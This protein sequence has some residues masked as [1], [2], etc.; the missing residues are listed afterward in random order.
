[1]TP[2]QLPDAFVGALRDLVEADALAL[3]DG[4]PERVVVERSRGRE[5]GDYAS[6][7]ALQLAGSAGLPAR[8]LAGL[9]AARLQSAGGVETVEVAGPGFLNV[10]LVPDGHAEVAARVVSAGPSYGGTVGVTGLAQVPGVVPGVLVQRIGADAARYATARHGTEAA[11]DLDLWSRASSDN[12]VYDVQHAHARACSILRNADVLG[13]AP[14][15]HP[16]LLTHERERDLLL[17]LADFPPVV[18]TAAA[19][20][21]PRRLARHLEDTASAFH[22]F[23]DTCRALSVG[24]EEPTPLHQA[25]LL[26]VAAT[27]VVL[28]NG[29]DLLGVRAPERM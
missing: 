29:L 2:D 21:E 6:N 14:T 12:P 8:E 16:A 26:L 18:A 23:A 5:Q 24:D 17:A 22:R 11:L 19:R 3:R 25:R 7:V 4:V 15:D 10:R 1:M 9:L 27:R 13:I 28:A 20:R